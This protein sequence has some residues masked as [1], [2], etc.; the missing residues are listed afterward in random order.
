MDGDLWLDF[1]GRFGVLV[2]LMA[3]LFLTA[4]W[5]G[6][7]DSGFVR[8]PYIPQGKTHAGTGAGAGDSGG[9]NPLPDFPDC[10]S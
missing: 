6:K 8:A 5:V 3:G 2:F 1:L 9:G 10:C 7:V 4:F